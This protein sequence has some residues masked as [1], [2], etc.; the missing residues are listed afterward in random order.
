LLTWAGAA[1]A[2][3]QLLLLTIVLLVLAGAY[4]WRIAAEEAM[5]VAELGPTYA[6]YQQRTWRLVPLIF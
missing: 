4:A 2:Q 1:A 3:G 5:L 6:A